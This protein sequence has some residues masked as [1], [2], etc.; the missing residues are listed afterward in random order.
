[1]D[2]ATRE[3]LAVTHGRRLHGGND[4]VTHGVS[5]GGTVTMARDGGETFR[6]IVVALLQSSPAMLQ[7]SLAM[8]Q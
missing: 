6:N 3:L 2:T 7:S 1:M 5:G 8:R 4:T